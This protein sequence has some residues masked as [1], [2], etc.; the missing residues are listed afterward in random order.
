M[1]MMM[2]MMMTMM[3]SQRE[4]E[5]G[6]SVG[7]QEPGLRGGSTELEPSAAPGPRGD[8][9]LQRLLLRQRDQQWGRVVPSPAGPHRLPPALVG[10]RPGHSSDVESPRQV[11]EADTDQAGQQQVSNL[12]N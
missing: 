4:P 7:R 8:L 10:L 9:P 11:S 6:R 12:S 1:M 5:R 3:M 2:M